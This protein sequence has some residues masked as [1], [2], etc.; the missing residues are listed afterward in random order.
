[1]CPITCLRDHPPASTGFVLSAAFVLRS[2]GSAASITPNNFWLSSFIS[3]RLPIQNSRTVSNR[4]A[5]HL[6]LSGAPALVLYGV[7]PLTLLC[8][9]QSFLSP[10][11]LFLVWKRSA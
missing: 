6:I 3:S 5:P 11:H 4:P 2:F 7:D 8:L 1:M 10:S 9:E